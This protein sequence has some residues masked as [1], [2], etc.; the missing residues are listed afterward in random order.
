[1]KIHLLLTYVWVGLVASSFGSSIKVVVEGRGY[2]QETA[3]QN[4]LRHAVREGIDSLSPQSND[5]DKNS[6]PDSL[7]KDAVKYVKS[8]MILNVSEEFGLYQVKAAVEVSKGDLRKDLSAQKLLYESKN[9]PRLM[10]LLEEKFDG[11]E[12]SEKTATYKF[13]EVLLGKGFKIVD[14]KQWKDVQEQ[15][16]ARALADPELAD[17]A[18]RMGADLVV[19]GGVTAGKPEQKL[20]YGKTFYTVPVQ[21]NAHIV[22]AD[23][24]EIIASKTKRVKKTSQEGFSAAQFGLETGGTELAQE[25]MDELLDYWN[26]ENY[27]QARIEL[28]VS[29]M[30]EK[31]AGQFETRLKQNQF[32]KNMNLRYIEKTTS[33]WDVE[34]SGSVQDLR[35]HFSS[36]GDYGLVVSG[37]SSA[38]LML[39]KDKNKV[40]EVAFGINSSHLEISDFSIREIFPSRVSYYQN[41]P[42]A[43]IKLKTPEPVKG[44]SLQI[45]IPRLMDAPATTQISELNAGADKNVQIQLVLNSEKLLGFTQSEKVQG[46]I[47]VSYIH[48]GNMVHRELTTPVQVYDRNTMDWVEPK[49]LGTFVTYRDPAVN[50]FARDALAEKTNEYELNKN[51]Q[52]AMSIFTALN[53]QGIKYVKDPLPSP[54][55]RILDRV[56]YPRETL[57]SKTGDCDDTSVLLAALLTSVGME[58]AII[59]YTDHVLLMFNTG[60]YQKNQVSLGADAS[61]VIP[62][63]GKLW[64]PLETTLINKG[65]TEAWSVAANE[66]HEAVS[67]GERLNVIELDESWK[68]YAAAPMQGPEIPLSIKE[69]S[70]KIDEEAKRLQRAITESYGMAIKELESQ[71][72][73]NPKEDRR[74]AI[75][76]TQLERY[77]D[78]HGLLKK[79]SQADENTR[80]K[81]NLGNSLLLLGKE[82]EAIHIY[83][84]ALKKEKLPGVAINRAL[85]YYLKAQ[86]DKDIESFIGAL[87][88]A[89]NL[90]PQGE[91][92]DTYLGMD[93]GEVDAKTKA[94]GER[95]AEKKQT[96]NQRRLKELIRT[97]VLESKKVQEQLKNLEVKSNILPYGGVRGADPDQIA[98]VVDLL[99]WYP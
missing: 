79:V 96:L 10:V 88:D 11:Q 30:G 53:A 58:T 37:L 64:I 56:Q 99:Y 94:S 3:L 43:S 85:A 25:L 70:N 49:T 31:E 38:R 35:E 14:P 40:T 66:F 83:E 44:V 52:Q 23:N 41:N 92:M 33:L 54:G 91:K 15:D 29:G 72:K 68:L 90:L 65:F 86:D 36:Q 59:S 20:I 57:K 62:H 16:K 42:T 22:R 75:L 60:L 97:R 48:K 8:H 24:A 50:A 5:L 73:R 51:I 98:Q 1:M 67:A 4:A 61:R 39:K 17:L 93:L 87:K 34:L 28:V 21:L 71:Q 95:E 55:E 9:K 2:T 74:L 32:I 45:F 27:A 78:A 80:N 63:K 13:Q 7:L 19:R 69:L 81:S 18:F 89:N 77:D 76:Y 46:N 47:K 82:K 26:S 12:S 6:K 84:D